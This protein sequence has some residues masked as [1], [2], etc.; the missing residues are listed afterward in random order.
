[1]VVDHLDNLQEV[2]LG[3]L[4]QTVR[5]LLHV[6]GLLLLTAV[7]LLQLALLIRWERSRLAQKLLQG[8]R[9]ILELD[10]MD[11]LV[12]R[13]SKV[14]VV[15]NGRLAALLCREQVDRHLELAPS[16]V[17]TLEGGFRKG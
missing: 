12:L 14:E 13:S 3:Q 10:G 15:L 8:L 2:V 16:F 9:G 6:K 7:D 4:D 5:H 1:M 17:G 11:V